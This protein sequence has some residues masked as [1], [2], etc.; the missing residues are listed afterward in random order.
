MKTKT[1]FVLLTLLLAASALMLTGQDADIQGRIISGEKPKLA[2]PDLRGAGLAQKFMQA[3]NDTL[4]NDLDNAGVL[5]LVAKSVYPLNVPQRPE[6]F[7]PPNAIGK[8][9]GPWLTDWSGSPVN[10][11]DLAFGYA[12]E[13]GGLFVVLGNLYNLSQPTPAAATLFGNKRY[14]GSLDE[15]GAKKVARDFA[16]DILAQF[17]GK[18]LSGTKIYFDSDR[19]GPRTLPDGTKVGVKEIWSMDYDGSNQ[20]QLTNYKSLSI[21]PTVS[22][23][24]T[25]FAFTSYP[26]QERGGHLVDGNPQIMIHSVEPNRRLSFYNPVSSVVATP[27]FT[28]DGKHVLFATKQGADKDEK[29]YIAN[30]QGG[31]LNP[32]SHVSAIEEEPKVNP[33]NGS[34]VA[35]ISGRT[36]PQEQLWLMSIDGGGAEMLTPGDGYVANPSWRPDGQW[37]AFAWTHGYEYGQFNIFIMNVSTRKYIQLTH[38]AGVNENPT[39]AP[40]GLHIVFTSKRGRSTQIFTM[41]ADGTHVQQ[42]TTQGNNFQP[43][44]AK[45]LN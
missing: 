24:G 43:V 6:D 31:D 16:A 27:E 13:Q 21:T 36:G 20:V 40:D 22:A 26:Q 11:N 23:D 4:W 25:M 7:V 15:A 35:F 30:L 32:I 9:T 29:I 37:I 19:T 1:I 34:Q 41:L 17:G 14:V 3:F 18:S 42:L 28:P 8:S 5:T 39:W 12:A 38:N 10:A 33:K 2:V 44:W 45:G